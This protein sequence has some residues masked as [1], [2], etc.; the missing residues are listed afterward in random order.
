MTHRANN[1]E[2]QANHFCRNLPSV[3]KAPIGNAKTI[4]RNP[5]MLAPALEYFRADAACELAVTVNKEVAVPL[6]ETVKGDGLN[7]Q[8]ISPDELEHAKFT[9]PLKPFTG[10]TLT[11]KFAE[12]PA[13]TVALAG[14]TEGLK[15]QTCCLGLSTVGQCTF[16]PP[17]LTVHPGQTSDG[18]MSFSALANVAQGIHSSPDQLS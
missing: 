15:S 2:R 16:T 10:E 3:S 12:P 11:L 4:S 8:E 17:S 5:R 13:P 14:L 6:A 18:S 9:V 7:E 1:K